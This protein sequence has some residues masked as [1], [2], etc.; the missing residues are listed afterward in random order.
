AREAAAGNRSLGEKTDH[1]SSVRSVSRRNPP[2]AW[3]LLLDHRSARRR[4]RLATFLRHPGRQSAA[5]RMNSTVHWLA[6]FDP[7]TLLVAFATIGVLI[8]L[9]LEVLALRRLAKVRL[10]GGAFYFLLGAVFV[11]LG[12]V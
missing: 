11:L 3:A 12:V 2:L 7:R 8:A 1:G 9:P 4:A 5:S 10:V 6:Q